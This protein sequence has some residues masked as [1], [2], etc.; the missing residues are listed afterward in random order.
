MTVTIDKNTVGTFL[1]KIISAGIRAAADVAPY[2]EA[3]NL[4]QIVSCRRWCGAGGVLAVDGKL[5]LGVFGL[6]GTLS[7]CLVIAGA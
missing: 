5:D 1:T 3:W 4:R 7:A 2:L 6:R